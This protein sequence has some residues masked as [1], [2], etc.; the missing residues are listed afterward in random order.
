MKNAMKSGFTLIELLVVV[1]IIAVI[2][3]G[4]AV[5]YNRLD[6][7]AK[8]AMEMNDIS[9]LEETINNW[10]FLHEGNLPNKLDSLVTTDGD[11]YSQMSMSGTSGAGLYAQAGFTFVASDA[12]NAVITQLRN[13]GINTVYRHL[14]TATVANDSTFTKSARDNS[15]STSS[16]IATL[17]TS[18]NDSSNDDKNRYEAI[19]AANDAAMEAL[20]QPEGYDAED[21]STHG[22]YT[23]TYTVTWETEDGAGGSATYTDANDWTTAYND[24]VELRNADATKTLAFVYPGGGSQMPMNLAAEIISN[25]GLDP[26]VI[27]GPDDKTAADLTGKKYWL[28]VFGLGRFSNLYEGKAARINAP[29][30]GKRYAS[31]SSIYNRYLLVVK[32]PVSGYNSMSNLGGEKASVATILSPIGLSR[33]RL[34]NTYREA[35]EATQN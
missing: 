32:V 19:I 24:A 15:I 25:A 5:T 26:N 13:V 8:T 29:V 27:A 4:V 28:V 21:E 18:S 9:V 7:R 2:G 35:V 23:G 33:A 22:N 10:S 11:L 34:D 1:A 6:E 16:T 20:V 14:T 31:D 17:Q 3:A 12:P 30:S